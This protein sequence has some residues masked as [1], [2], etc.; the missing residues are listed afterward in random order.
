MVKYLQFKLKV[1]GYAVGNVDGVFGQNTA[2]AVRAFQQA[3]GLTPDGI[4]GR[5]SKIGLSWI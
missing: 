2:S 4:V 5:K 1:L 3:N